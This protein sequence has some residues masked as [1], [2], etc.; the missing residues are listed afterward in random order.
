MHKK[1][2][3][4]SLKQHHKRRDSNRQNAIWCQDKPRSSPQDIFIMDIFFISI[5]RNSENWT[6]WCNSVMIGIYRELN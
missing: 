6:S 5:V 1:S 3:L 4:E 2:R